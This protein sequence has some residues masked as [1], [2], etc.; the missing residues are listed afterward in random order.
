MIPPLPPCY[1][2]AGKCRCGRCIVE[3]AVIV[4]V[5]C[6]LFL[7]LSYVAVFNL[8]NVTHQVFLLTLYIYLQEK[9]TLLRRRSTR[10]PPQ[11]PSLLAITS[12]VSHSFMRYTISRGSA[13][14]S[15]SLDVGVAA[16]PIPHPIPISLYTT[17]D[18]LSSSLC[19]DL[20]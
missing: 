13:H 18:N 11:R 12:Q 1:G 4:I 3:R 6:S 9:N 17:Q 15:L 16:T 2:T 7:V 8:P 19:W 20:T 5:S 14:S 10:R